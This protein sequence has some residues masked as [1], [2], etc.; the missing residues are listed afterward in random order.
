MEEGHTYG[1]IDSEVGNGSRVKLK[2]DGTWKFVEE[3][4]GSFNAW[5]QKNGNQFILGVLTSVVAA[6]I[7]YK[8]LKAK[9]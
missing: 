6:I 4:S 7:I 8:L 1:H 5:I 9:S 3:D 2:S